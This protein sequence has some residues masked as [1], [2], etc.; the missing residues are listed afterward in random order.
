MN[1]NI[2]FDKL[3]K[4]QYES[5]C[6]NENNIEVSSKFDFAY[7][8]VNRRNP[9]YTPVVDIDKIRSGKK[10]PVWPEG[11]PFAV[12]ITHDVDLVT[13]QS[14]KQV[15]R[16]YSSKLKSSLSVKNV[17]GLIWNSYN[18]LLKKRSADPLPSFEKWLAVEKENGA[19]ST[20]FFWPGFSHVGK[21]HFSDCS[22]D[23]SDR[24]NFEGRKKTIA[25]VIR[26]IDR[27]GWEIGLH[28]SWHSY[29]DVN[30][31]KT[32]KCALEKVLNH[33]ICSIRQHYL[34]YDVR[35][36]PGAHQKAG[37]KYDST[38]GF[39]DNIGFRFGT[40]YPWMIYDIQ[41]NKN[42]DVLEVPL[43]IMDG[44]LLHQSKGMRLNE[45]IAFEYIKQITEEVEKV[46]GVLTILWH[47]NSIINPEWW[48][49]FCRSLSY[50]K[51]R[52]AWMTNIKNLGNYWLTNNHGNG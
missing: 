21:K 4:G 36:T 5:E 52:N 12:C 1:Q 25:Q 29:N 49:L 10:K 11:K 38:L 30:E 18:T 37:F 19:V 31:L 7:N 3:L 41:N 6:L 23:L 35:C 15:L 34:H 2:N 20:F 22:Y 45:E 51:E 33:E 24:I 32:Q 14:I 8:T 27:R 13:S 9:L 46:A 26:E 39:N 28:S 50:F 16:I 42:L 43:V 17:G 40:S 44:G 48:N 47:P